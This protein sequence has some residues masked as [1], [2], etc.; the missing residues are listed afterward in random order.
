MR[1]WFVTVDE[2]LSSPTC[3]LTDQ[4][5]Q[6]QTGQHNATV[7]ATATLDAR[8]QKPFRYLPSLTSCLRRTGDIRME[9]RLWHGKPCKSVFSGTEFIDWVLRTFKG[10]DSRERAAI[11]ASRMLQGGYGKQYSPL[12][13]GKQCIRLY[14]DG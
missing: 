6:L 12:W 3:M 2:Y 4:N 14:M 9:N 13:G 1:T 8:M 11:F 7:Q 5:P 10:V